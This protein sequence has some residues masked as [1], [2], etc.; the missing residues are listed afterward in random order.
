M[1]QKTA[2]RVNLWAG[3]VL[4]TSFAVLLILAVLDLTLLLRTHRVQ[5]DLTHVY[6]GVYFVFWGALAVARGTQRR[7][8]RERAQRLVAKEKGVGTP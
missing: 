6:F 7:A 3:R 1:T 4:W 5:T 2:S 8:S